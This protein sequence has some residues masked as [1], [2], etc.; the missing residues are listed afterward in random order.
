MHRKQKKAKYGGKKK[1]KRDRTTKQDS[2][3]VMVR[4]WEHLERARERARRRE[5]KKERQR[6]REGEKSREKQS[7]ARKPKKAQEIRKKRYYKKRK[8]NEI[9]FHWQ[10]V[11]SEPFTMFAC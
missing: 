10:F 1:R 11:T 2:V 8:I 9:A 4:P 3:S 7:E 6:E 5:R